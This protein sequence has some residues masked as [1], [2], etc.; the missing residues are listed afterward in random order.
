[1][2]TNNKLSLEFFSDWAFGINYRS[3]VYCAGR[4]RAK[5]ST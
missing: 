3:N 4:G 2:K 1:M 5:S